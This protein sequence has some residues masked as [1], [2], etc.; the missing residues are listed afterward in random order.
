M[1]ELFLCPCGGWSIADIPS[2]C[3]RCRK[4]YDPTK[5]IELTGDMVYKLYTTKKKVR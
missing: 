3:V 4:P 2:R 1:A 5:G